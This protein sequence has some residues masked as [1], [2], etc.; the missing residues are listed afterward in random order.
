MVSAQT[1]V[2]T[3]TVATEWIYVRSDS[4]Y[5]VVIYVCTVCTERTIL[6]VPHP[7]VHS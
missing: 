5:W 2:Y 3:L 6:P 1:C 7:L 4:M